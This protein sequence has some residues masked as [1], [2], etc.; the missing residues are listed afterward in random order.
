MQRSQ[1]ETAAGQVLSGV[2]RRDAVEDMSAAVNNFFDLDA[3]QL[4]PGDMHC[5]IDFIAAGN[6]FMYLENYPRRTHLTGELLHNRFG[7]AIP[8]A[9]PGLKFSGEQMDHC[10]LASAMT[11][12]EMDVFAPGGLKQFVV[13][14][15]HARLLSMADEVGL[16]V[17]VHRALQRG[18]PTMPLVVKPSAVALLGNHLRHLLCLVAAGELSMDAAGVE[19]FLYAQVLSVLDAKEVP[20]GLPP[21]AVLVRRATE[22]ADNHRGPVRIAQLCALL[23]VSLG[24]LENSFKLVTGLTPHT[25]FLRRRLNQARTVL[26]REDPGQRNVTNIATELGFS[27]LGRFAVRYREMFGERPSVTLRRSPVTVAVGR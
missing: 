1:K 22:I 7:L 8:V 6:T 21:A 18:R 12:E 4:E 2:I 25:F 27:E 19:D 23:R 10:R 9:G 20:C 26:L 15:D 17:D 14:L 11:G 5:R 24:T 16:P 3:V 13:L